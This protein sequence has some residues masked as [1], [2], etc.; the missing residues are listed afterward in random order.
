MFTTHSEGAVS[1][2]M[3]EGAP[4]GGLMRPRRARRGSWRT[5]W[6]PAPSVRVVSHSLFRRIQTAGISFSPLEH[7][8]HILSR[9]SILAAESVPRHRCISIGSLK[10]RGQ[11][12]ANKEIVCVKGSPIR[13]RFSYTHINQSVPSRIP[14]LVSLPPISV[15]SDLSLSTLST[16][17][18]LANSSCH[19]CTCARVGRSS[20]EH[21]VGP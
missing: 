9:H 14:Q 20:P 4:G 6:F 8:P 2:S 17:C 18:P 15:S 5:K 21:T 12:L 3:G 11:S 7:L 13:P 10:A 1:E 16:P 19:C